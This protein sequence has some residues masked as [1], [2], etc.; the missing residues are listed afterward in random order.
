LRIRPNLVLMVVGFFLLLSVTP[1]SAITFGSDV[2]NASITYPD[3]VSIWWTQ[4]S[5]EVPQFICTGNLIGPR[6]VL[7]A[8]HC[9]IPDG[10]LYVATG[11]DILTQETPLIA[12]S[13]TWR[14]PRYSESQHVNDL[15]LLLLDESVK[16]ITPRTV[17][18]SSQI[19][20]LLKS[21]GNKFEIVGWGVNQNAEDATYLRRVSV[22]DQTKIAYSWRNW[23]NNVWMAVGAY[24]K[25]ERIYAGAC[26]GDS[27]GP[28][29]AINNGHRTLVGIASWGAKGCEVAKPSA[30][31]RL[32]YYISDLKNGAIALR[33]NEKT[34]NRL[35][36]PT[37]VTTTSILGL[38]D[39]YGWKQNNIFECV[40]AIAT[41]NNSYRVSWEWE[42]DNKTFSTS[43]TISI[44][45]DDV[46]KHKVGTSDATLQCDTWATGSSG[47]VTEDYSTV[48]T[49]ALT[50]PLATVSVGD[51]PSP[52][53][54][55]A[56][57]QCTDLDPKPGDLITWGSM[58]S[59]DLYFREFGPEH[60]AMTL[61]TGPY[62][63]LNRDVL[64]KLRGN[65]LVCLITRSNAVGSSTAGAPVTWDPRVYGSRIDY[66][67]DSLTVDWLLLHTP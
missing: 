57:I 3:V 14:H 58:D 39:P 64:S 20:S 11:R 9:A 45:I 10:F 51:F 12:V 41:G 23:N 34:N 53:Y 54:P 13:A 50:P 6:T 66:L 65:L 63:V 7:T 5:S 60:I 55:N 26:N 17:D 44:S 43:Q 48:T 21:K 47:L 31:V 8:A 27:G 56:V 36:E 24:N 62:I 49:E 28:L 2:Q 67:F 61:G 52:F 33:T 32:S 38:P 40:P 15:A 19:A 1:A 59:L 16:G 37:F 4:S 29:Y 18:S 30:Y 46:K 22:N 42:D 35:A 25:I